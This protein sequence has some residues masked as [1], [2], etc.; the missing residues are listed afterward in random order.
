MRTTKGEAMTM[1]DVNVQFRDE[2]L[3]QIAQARAI[4][5]ANQAALAEYDSGATQAALDAKLAAD[6]AAG[7]TRMVGTDRY[8]VLEGWDRNEI[9][10]VRRAV[11]P[12]E[13]PLILP[14]S[15][16]DFVD[17]K[18]QLYLAQPAWHELGN[19]IPGGIS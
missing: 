3:G 11:R 8:E 15:G 14:E 6:V 17:D 4:V 1:T 7:T 18:A 9:F 19:V 16:L 5:E 12:G 10:T 2:K 13:I